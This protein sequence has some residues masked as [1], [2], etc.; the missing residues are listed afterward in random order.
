MAVT[1]IGGLLSSTAMSLLI[2]PTVF[3]YVEGLKGRL[4]KW[5]RAGDAA[6]T[7]ELQA[8]QS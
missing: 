4:R 5:R 8:A 3:T 6:A 1:V 2:V 7:P